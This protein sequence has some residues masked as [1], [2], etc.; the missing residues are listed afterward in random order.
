MDPEI[1]FTTHAE[2][3]SVPI[4]HPSLSEQHYALIALP[5]LRVMHFFTMAELAAAFALLTG[6]MCPCMAFSYYS[7]AHV[8]VPME[9]KVT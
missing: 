3:R 2:V 4:G 1:D 5:E 8:W 9:I 7:D 6:T